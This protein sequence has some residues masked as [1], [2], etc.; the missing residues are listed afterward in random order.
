MWR[1]LIETVVQQEGRI[2]AYQAIEAMKEETAQIGRRRDL[3]DL[4]DIAL[5]AQE[6]SGPESAVFG[7]VIGAFDPD[8]E[9]VV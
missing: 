6:R 7:T 3:A 8:P 5:P 9:A 2:A 1:R 4:F